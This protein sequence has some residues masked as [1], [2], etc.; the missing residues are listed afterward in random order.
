[1]PDRAM[2]EKESMPISVGDQTFRILV[3]PAERERYAR[4]ARATNKVLQDVARGGAMNAGR[5]Y[6]MALF[7]MA[8][9]LDEARQALA[10]STRD[11]ERLAD[12]IRR[13]D[14]VT[15]KPPKKT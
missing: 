6:A 8:V 13:I 10:Q 2:P 5:A 11:I 7:Q 15:D 14:Q 1:M 12:L 3:D 9:E 4:A